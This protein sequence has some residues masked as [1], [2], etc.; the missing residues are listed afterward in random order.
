MLHVDLPTSDQLKRLIEE[1]ADACVSIYL[2]THAHT[3]HTDVDRLELRRLT[4]EA[5]D[6][7]RAK[8]FDT[9]RLAAIEEQFSELGRDHEFWR[10]QSS[11]LAALATPDRLRTFRLPSR[12]QPVAQVSDRFHLKPMIRAVTFPGVAFVLAL[13]QGS[14]RLIEVTPDG[15]AEEVSVPGMPASLAEVVGRATGR[16]PARPSKLADEGQKV[17]IRQYARE[18]DRALRPVLAAGATPLILAGV[19]Y[20]LPIYRSVNSYAN[21]ADEAITGNVEHLSAREIA[22]QARDTLRGLNDST[23]ADLRERFERWRGLERATS[24][25]SQIGRAVFAGAVHTLLFDV[26]GAVHG[27]VDEQTGAVEIASEASASTYDVVDELM[28]RTILYGG[29]ALGVRQGDLPDPNSP[30][31]ALLRYPA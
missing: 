19:D 18:V 9:R 24:D 27:R 4:E 20:L 26:D 2:P 16:D 14:A 8:G 30:L 28:G 23:I 5:L 3:Q 22:E 29:E 17:Q 25:L 13:S 10:F 12:L 21:L 15:P 11:S 7:L 1:R 31:A 6:Q